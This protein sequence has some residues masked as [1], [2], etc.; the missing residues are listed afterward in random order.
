MENLPETGENAAD[1]ELPWQA[2]PKGLP[3]NNRFKVV[4]DW[5]KWYSSIRHGIR[6]E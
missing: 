2:E 1:Q 5:M 4:V 3:G 6:R